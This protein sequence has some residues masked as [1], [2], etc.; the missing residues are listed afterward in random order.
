MKRK[1]AKV[2]LPAQRVKPE[3]LKYLMRVGPHCGGIG[4]AIDSA[5]TI[6][7]NLTNQAAKR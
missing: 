4:S 6:V 1:V 7:E 2:T 5:V 3:T